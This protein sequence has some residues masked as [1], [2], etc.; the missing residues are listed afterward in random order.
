M[1]EKKE[2]LNEEK[3][4]KTSKGLLIS[5]I[6]IIILGFVVAGLIAAPKLMDSAKQ[7]TEQ[8]KQQLEELKPKLQARYDELKASGV[9]ESWDY[10]N[11][12][13][14]EM[15][16]IDSALD[17]TL[18]KCE[19]TSTYSEHETTKEYCRIK[20]LI[21]D[22]SNSLIK[23][24]TLHSIIPAIT[25]LIPFLGIGLSLILTAKRRN[26]LAYS[27]QQT[28]PVAQEGIEKIAPTIGKARATIVKE[29][30]PVYGEI[31][32]EIGK[33]IKEGMKDQN[34]CSHCG[35]IVSNTAVYCESCG[36]KIK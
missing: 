32:K 21:Y 34:K 28:M 9:Q 18:K 6:I 23:K 14:Y 8:L 20:A 27:V 12:E 30:A 33:G 3:Y 31:A 10:K 35:A 19:F 16:L 4:Q 11:P 26:I 17:P 24:N 5:G 22:S 2:L 13:G 1:E 15:H 25:V 36:K 7:N 29:M